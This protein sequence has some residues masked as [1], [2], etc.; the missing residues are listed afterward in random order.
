MSYV[1]PQALVYPDAELLDAAITDPL[2][3]CIVGGN[4]QLFRYVDEKLLAYLGDH[5]HTGSHDDDTTWEYPNLPDDSIVDQDYVKLYADNA[6]LLY[7]RDD[8]CDDAPFSSCSLGETDYG[9]VTPV[10]GYQNRIRNDVVAYIENSF[11]GVTY[12]RNAC[13]IDR[14]CQIGDVVDLEGSVPVAYTLRTR[15]KDFHGDIVPAVIGDPAAGD[16]NAADQ[17]EDCSITQTA[18]D[19][20]CV[21]AECV[22]AG[23]D[24]LADGDITETYTITV[25][26]G[27]TGGDFTTALLRVRSASGNDDDDDV[28]PSMAGVA[29]NIGSRGFQVIFTKSSASSCSW[30]AG[31][32]GISVDDPLLG[33]IWTGQ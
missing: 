3:A 18:G 17:A 22:S 32:E 21:E 9:V 4:A 28:V 8:I 11:R 26:Q 20:N 27:S 15:I 16:D 25:T 31:E 19:V 2:R 29:T 6:L 33:Q 7:H 14:D 13:F 23:Y 12:P 24:G 5:V 30:E 10:S 1:V